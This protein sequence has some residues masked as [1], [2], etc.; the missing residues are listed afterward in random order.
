MDQ[1]TNNAAVAQE[2]P[3]LDPTIQD[4]QERNKIVTQI[5]EQTPLEKLT[6]SYLRILTEYLVYPLEKEE[7]RQKKILTENRMTTVNKREISFEGLVEKFQNGEDGIYNM[8]TNDKNIIFTPKYNITP[9]DIQEVPGLR[10]LV[11][12]IEQVQKEY[13]LATGKKKALLLKQL[14]EMRKDQYVLKGSYR[15]PI[16]F[17][18]AIKSFNK[19]SFQEKISV[20]E[21]GSLKIEGNFSFLIPEHVEAIL[22]NYLKIKQ[23]CWGKFESDSYYLIQDLE[24]LIDITL[25]D[26][27][28]LYYDLVAYKIVGK[29]NEEIQALLNRDYGIKHSVEYLSSLWRKKIPKMIAERAQKEWLI[30]HYTNEERG[31]WKKCNRCGE[32]KLAHNMFFSKNNTSKD[33]WYSICKDCRNKKTKEKKMLAKGAVK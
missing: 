22:C 32:I 6:P 12:S 29:T 2:L 10:Q 17:M 4:P 16:Y 24:K 26:D 23:T 1:T 7:R 18:N 20:K 13:E 19:I 27:Y 3:R 5:V 14:I 9:K 31:K 15:K 28:P 11:D 8:I 30:W 21:D 33:G 25:K